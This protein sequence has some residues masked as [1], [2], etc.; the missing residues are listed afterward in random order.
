MHSDSSTVNGAAGAFGATGTTRR[1]GGKVIATGAKAAARKQE[2]RKPGRDAEGVNLDDRKGTAA[3]AAN[4][5]TFAR[6]SLEE[7][8]SIG[9]RGRDHADAG[10]GGNPALGALDG[11]AGVECAKGAAVGGKIAPGVKDAPGAR[12]PKTFGGARGAGGSSG[13]AGASGLHDGNATPSGNA[14]PGSGA[15]PSDS[16]IPNGNATP[17]GDGTQTDGGEQRARAV[18]GAGE[19]TC[20]CDS[21]SAK[22]RKAPK[23]VV[24]P[25]LT[26]TPNPELVAIAKEHFANTRHGNIT[27]WLNK[28]LLRELRKDAGKIRA[29]GIKIPEWLF[30]K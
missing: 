13:A 1:K 6:T 29:A 7:S 20:G 4:V 2:T 30:L 15:K 10:H 9:G 12:R 11:E 19:P 16:T 5:A 21:A 22:S 25:T 24:K 8:P 28:A 26:L 17:N 27:T 14:L 3:G 18:P 23:R